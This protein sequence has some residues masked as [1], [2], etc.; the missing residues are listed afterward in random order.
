MK[1]VY[2]VFLH[3]CHGRGCATFAG[4]IA[5]ARACMK[6]YESEPRAEEFWHSLRDDKSASPINV[7]AQLLL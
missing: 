4:S 3:I 6:T 7:L 1:E 5:A 2:K